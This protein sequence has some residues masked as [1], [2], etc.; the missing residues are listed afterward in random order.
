[1]A[2]SQIT[3]RLIDALKPRQDE[4][5]V[6]AGCSSDFGVRVQSTGGDVLCREISSRQR[7]QCPY[8]AS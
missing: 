3:K 8:K 5:F 7:P 4:Y 2:T 6:S 1:M